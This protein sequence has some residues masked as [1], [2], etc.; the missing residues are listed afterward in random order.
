MRPG[1]IN[2]PIFPVF[3]AKL[4]GPWGPYQV[5]LLPPLN[6]SSPFLLFCLAA[7]C[8]AQKLIAEM[9]LKGFSGQSPEPTSLVRTAGPI[10]FTAFLS[11]AS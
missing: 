6:P 9:H 5:V 3:S 11:Y 4:T 7:H 8:V 10:S 1:P 2:R